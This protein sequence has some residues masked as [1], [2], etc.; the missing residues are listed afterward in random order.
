MFGKVLSSALLCLV[1]AQGAIAN[2]KPIV[3]ASNQFC[4]E[5]IGPTSGFHRLNELRLDVLDVV[6]GHDLE[7][8]TWRQIQ[9]PE[10]RGDR[11]DRGETGRTVVN[12]SASI[13]A[14]GRNKPVRWQNQ[15]IHINRLH[16]KSLTAQKRVGY[17]YRQLIQVGH[18]QE[19][20]EN[21][22]E[23]HFYTPKCPQEECCTVRCATISITTNGK[24]SDKN[25]IKYLI[26][27][28][29][30]I[31][32]AQFVLGSLLGAILSSHYFTLRKET[33]QRM[34]FSP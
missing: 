10:A 22:G 33:R 25:R 28:N 31:R 2:P 4:C 24:C 8:G 3:G 6:A 21:E 19:A 9:G 11:D 30:P 5:P 18:Q 14:L 34:H 13:P 27:H 16:L 32:H 26:L 7:D 29:P 12:A 20:L 15:R 17:T 1:L 23:K